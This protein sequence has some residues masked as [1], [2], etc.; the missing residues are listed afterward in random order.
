MQLAKFKEVTTD[1]SPVV[2]IQLRT[3]RGTGR[4]GAQ[5]GMGREINREGERVVYSFPFPSPLTHL[6]PCHM[7]ITREE[8]GTKPNFLKGD[9]SIERAQCFWNRGKDTCVNILCLV[10]RDGVVIVVSN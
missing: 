9:E 6:A 8:S 10:D 3:A 1:L 7:E 5:G 4:G 2:F